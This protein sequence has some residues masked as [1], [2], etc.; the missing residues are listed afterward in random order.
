MHDGILKMSPRFREKKTTQAAAIL[1]QRDG[2]KT[3]YIKLLKLLY[4]ADRKSLEETG[5]PIT[6]DTYV[7]MKYG[8]VLSTTYD[9]IKDTSFNHG[10]YWHEYISQPKDY[11][12]RLNQS[13][14]VTA[15]SEVEIRILNQTFD[16]YGKIPRFDLVDISHQFP[17]FHEPPKGSTLPITYR[18]IFHALGEDEIE[19]SRIENELSFYT[20]LDS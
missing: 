17:E 15:L 9:L 14:S 7:S 5:F 11:V 20:N 10:D 13:P 2:G 16:E 6:F 19:I 4:I 1:L 8:P 12:V 18:D 3:H